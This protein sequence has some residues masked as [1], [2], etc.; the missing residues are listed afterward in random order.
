MRKTVFLDRDGV[1]NVRKMGGYIESLE[2]FDLLPGVIPA[3]VRLHREGWRLVV[4]T[5]QRGLAIGVMSRR[6]VDDIHRHLSRL[7]RQAGGQLDEFY[8]CPHDR[9]E[10][11]ACRKPQPGLL[12]AAF[13]R[14]PLEFSDAILVGDSDSDIAAGLARGVFTIKIGPPGN[15]QAHRH[16]RDLAHAVEIIFHGKRRHGKGNGSGSSSSKCS[17]CSSSSCATCG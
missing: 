11:C 9:H 8:V 4:V 12:D 15:P 13:D 1:I 3:L 14:Q 17:S 6:N 10:G 2:E 16:A 7:V 5:N